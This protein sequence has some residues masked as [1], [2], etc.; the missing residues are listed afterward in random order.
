MVGGAFRAIVVPLG[1]AI[2]V[3]VGDIADPFAL[4]SPEYCARKK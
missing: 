1:V 2:V 3:S 4:A